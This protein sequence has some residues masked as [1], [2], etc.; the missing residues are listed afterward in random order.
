LVASPAEPDWTPPTRLGSAVFAAKSAV[1]QARRGFED[2]IGGPARHGRGEA[3]GFPAVVAQSITP[4]W[5]DERQAEGGHQRGKVHNLR[6]ACAALNGVQIPAGQVF[7]FWRQVGP[8]TRA[9]GYASGRMLQQ[10][11]LVP[12]TGGGLCQLSNA[13]YQ[14][15]LDADCEIVER[16]GHSR[17]VPGSVA[18]VGRDATVA[19]NYVDLRFRPQQPLLIEARLTADQLIIRMRA[20]QATTRP[21]RAATPVIERALAN[22]RTCSTCNEAACFRHDRAKGAVVEDRTAWLVDEN[23]PEFQAYAAQACGPEDLLATPFADA[24]APTR[25]RWNAKGFQHRGSADVEAFSR[26]LA[27]R[28][29]W[30]TNAQRRQAELDSAGK[31]AKRL[32]RLAGPEVERLVVAQSLLPFLWREGELGGRRYDVLMTRPPMDALQAW[33]DAAFTR[34]PDRKSLSDFRAP[35]WLAEAERAALAGAA[36]VITPH[37]AIADLFGARAV[38]IPWST[39]KPQTRSSD[40]Q[41]RRIAFPGPTVARKGAWE[42]R[43]AARALD[44][45][46][47]LLGSELEGEGFWDGVRV[48]HPSGDWVDGVAAV[49]QPAVVEEQPRRLLAALAAG[50]PVVATPACGLRPREGLTIV[51]VGDAA[52]LTTSLG[53]LFGNA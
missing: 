32:A 49:V 9:R 37:A 10:G 45:Q 25:Y 4:L 50:V 24:I 34:H 33:L 39:P 38:E 15:A 16:H 29:N 48:M 53:R 6:R 27:L 13:L 30:P 41:P 36:R 44:L 28:R 12:S 51:P 14:A 17:V 23:W 52:A 35:P 8:A 47:M 7:S 3:P 43:E 42:V 1:F 22:V 20:A 40:V 46:V 5:S 26:V 11:C 21:L 31:I 19:W 2:L 18:E